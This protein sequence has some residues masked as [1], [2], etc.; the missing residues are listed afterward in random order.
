MV[1]FSALILMVSPV[2]NNPIVPPSCASGVMCPTTKP[3]VPPENRPSVIKATD[4]PKP[5]P[6]ISEVGLS[7]SG[8]PG[9]PF[10]PT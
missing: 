5:A 8:M 4:F 10:G 3:W 6:I 2:F 9:P 1:L 7:I